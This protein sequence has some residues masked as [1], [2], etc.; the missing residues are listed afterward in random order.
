M[1]CFQEGV[2]EASPHVHR[3]LFHFS[4]IS[5]G[6]YLHPV[7]FQVRNPIVVAMLDWPMLSL[8]TNMMFFYTNVVSYIE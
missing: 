1:L 5:A 2:R 7:L 4:G 8:L 6:G 3:G